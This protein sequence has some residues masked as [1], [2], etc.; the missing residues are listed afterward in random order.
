MNLFQSKKFRYGSVSLALTIIIIAAVILFNAIFTALSNKFLW[1]IDMT[2]EEIY[3]LS[4]DARAL[5]DQHYRQIYTAC[6]GGTTAVENVTYYTA[7]TDA[8]TGEITGYTEVAS[9]TPGVTDV[10]DY[11]TM[12]KGPD[13]TVIFCS[14]K[15]VLE[16]NTSQRYVLYTVLEL[17]K[18]YES[19][20][21]K[22]V[23][24]FTNPSEVSRY[25]ETSGQNITSQ[26]VIVTSGT[27]SR[28]YTLSALFT[29]SSDGTEVLGYNGEQRLVSAILAV[30]RAESPVVCVTNNHEE[31]E[32]LTADSSILTLLYETGYKVE[33][34]DLTR[35]EIPADCRLL[36]V[37]D[38]QS[39]FQV[40][41]G[42]SDISEL[43]KI[44]AYLDNNNAMMVFVNY[45]TP[46]LPNFEAFLEEWGIK[47]ARSG[48]TPYLIKDTETALNTSGYAVK[49]Q[50]TTAGLGASI[51]AQLRRAEYP[52]SV[53]FPMT[54]A[55]VNPD[56][57][58]EL[59][60]ENSGAWTAT[61]FKNGILRDSYDVF[62]SS[63]SA[64]ALVGGTTIMGASDLSGENA[65][66]YMK[67]TCETKSPEVGDT[68]YAY[69]LACASTEFASAS[70]LDSGYGN[71]TVVAYACNVLGRAVISVSLSCKYFTDTEIN[72]ITAKAANQYTVVLTV[73]PAG[74]IFV[75]GI[76]VMIRR[77]YA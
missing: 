17:E 15:D 31:T 29:Y 71:H 4:D 21:V 63:S 37:F 75:A 50:Y 7:D 70:A 66:S 62:L 23:D 67:V 49:G 12:R 10:S 18:A 74:I 69:V 33:E 24:V 76:Y 58:E 53:I 41:S 55:L 40:K 38:P 36:L 45:N 30:T 68:T 27:E 3:T 64:E 28:V 39:D 52:K 13:V 25:K 47:I 51:T 9:V 60:D 16:A 43:E 5:L 35:E 19:I 46:V 61:Y 6:T 22:Y 65:F 72:D 56:S 11:Y 2:P 34:I 1:Y 26:S 57:Y 77:K 44:D 8:S 59:Y 32:S 14:E 73:V 42:L 54:T 48:E 20:H